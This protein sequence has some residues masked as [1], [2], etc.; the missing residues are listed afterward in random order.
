MK[1]RRLL[2]SSRAGCLH[3][4]RSVKI[5]EV[6]G[7]PVAQVFGG[8]V[9]RSFVSPG[10]AR[11]EHLRRN[12]GT[13]F[14]NAEAEGGLDLKCLFNQMTFHGGIYHGARVRNFHA[15]SHAVGSA[16]PAGVDQPALG[17]VFAQPAS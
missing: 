10:I 1:S 11:I 15:L 5:F 7:E 4:W 17:V 2:L 6:L 13:G 12:S 8:L 9:V 3:F 14:G 16:L